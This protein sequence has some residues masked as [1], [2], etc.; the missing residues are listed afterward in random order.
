[1]SLRRWTELVDRAHQWA[2]PRQP[3]GAHTSLRP[4][5]ARVPRE[6]V[7]EQHLVDR[8]FW[9]G[10]VLD[11]IRADAAKSLS[12]AE[13][14]EYDSYVASRRRPSIPVLGAKG[15]P[16]RVYRAQKVVAKLDKDPRPVKPGGIIQG[17]EDLV[18]NI[19]ADYLGGRATEVFLILYVNVRNQIVGFNEYAEG[20]V[21][22]VAVNT[23]GI[24]RDALVSG[25]AAFITV[26]Q[27]PTG[28][29]TPSQEDRDL[30]K[31]LRSAGEIVGIPCLDNLVLGD[32][33]QYF[34][35][36]EGYVRKVQVLRAASK[37]A[38]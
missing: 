33:G 26:H 5:I 18:Q 27:H 23:A 30:W 17:P 12:S 11:D 10:E 8:G 7:D 38:P 24:L 34:S 36:S 15:N 22:G 3:F 21:A 20:S 19:L 2:D 14:R 4:Y 32:D 25:S 1:M 9:L 29:P 16:P 6:T 35:E 31:R 37:E 28:D 13:L